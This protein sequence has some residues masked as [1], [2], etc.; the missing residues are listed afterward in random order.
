MDTINLPYLLLN[1]RLFFIEEIQTEEHELCLTL[2]STAVQGTCPKCDQ[3][4]SQL[5]STYLRFPLDLPWAEWPVRLHLRAKR[6]FCRNRKCP[7]K[8]F[9]ERFPDFLA[10]YA[11]RTDRVRQKQQR[12]GV[13]VC[14]RTAEKLLKLDQVGISDTTVNRLLL[15]LPEP[16]QPPVRVLGV[17]DW[18]KRKGQRYGTILVDL[19]RGQIVDLLGERTAEPLVKWLEDHPGIKI[20]SRDR[21]QTYGDAIRR[22]A[23]DAIQVADRWHLLKNASEVIFKILQQE[24][25]TIRN[26]LNPEPKT[27]K[28][29]N[30]P[31]KVEDQAEDFTVAEQRRKDRIDLVRELHGRGYSQ[32]EIARQIHLHP[33]TVRRYLRAPTPTRRSHRKKRLLDPYHPYLLKRWNEGCHNATQLWREIQSQGFEGRLTIVLTLIQRFRKASGLPPNVRHLA[34]KALDAD[35]IRQPPALRTLSY[36]ILKRPENRKEEQEKLVEQIRAAQPELDA[37]LALAREFASMIRGRK[38]EELDPWLEKAEQSGYRVW[39]NF[40][41][42]LK[43]DYAA[44]RAAL[45][46]SWSNGP[47]EGHINR[48]KCLKR[49][50]YG[51]AKDDLLRK[52]VLWQGRWGFT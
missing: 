36:W 44:V 11:R 34:G 28:T 32:K 7:K 43:Q 15:D 8:T 24:Y 22:G 51:R 52:R 42:G 40:V 12:L 13:N 33:K 27:I 46:Y 23:S 14:A 2:E 17:D 48:L 3:E 45:S 20:V 26:L 5:H 19:E 29:D 30:H 4:S 1:T 50:M 9:V 41:A 38:A 10:R 37:T 47:T 16:E 39:D 31:T 6:F 18:A 21:S 35:S 49:L 25:V